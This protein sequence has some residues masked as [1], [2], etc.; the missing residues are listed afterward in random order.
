MPGRRKRAPDREPESA[1]TLSPYHDA[2]AFV[3]VRDADDATPAPTPAPEPVPKVKTTNKQATVP[4]ETFMFVRGAGEGHSDLDFVY[5][6]HV[7]RNAASEAE[8]EA[9]ERLPQL[10]NGAGATFMQRHESVKRKRD[11][12][13]WTDNLPSRRKTLASVAVLAVL[14]FGVAIVSTM[15]GSTPGTGSDVAASWAARAS[16]TDLLRDGVEA[17]GSAC[18]H[19]VDESICATI[20]VEGGY[21]M[22]SSALWVGSS[23]PTSTDVADAVVV[24]HDTPVDTYTTCRP[25]SEAELE[26]LRCF[27]VGATSNAYVAA[28]A[29]LFADEDGDDAWGRGPRVGKTS[30]T[31]AHLQLRCVPDRDRTIPKCRTAFAYSRT[32]STCF[33]DVEYDVDSMPLSDTFGWTSEIG[34]V[35]SSVNLDLVVADDAHVDGSCDLD[36]STSTIGTVRV[37]LDGNKNVKY[38]FDVSDLAYTPH[39]AKIYVGRTELPGGSSSASLRASAFSHAVSTPLGRSDFSGVVDAST[40]LPGDSHY[41]HT[42]IKLKVCQGDEFSLVDTSTAASTSQ[43]WVDSQDG[44]ESSSAGVSGIPRRVY[45]ASSGWRGLR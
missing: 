15:G 32:A 43:A 3:Y 18:V 34:P 11:D 1:T 26:T 45:E 16:C 4:R 36:A 23:V 35:D 14:G 44:G 40:D 28:S 17:V 19:V 7:A 12:A 22:E 38:E 42:I 9:A 37:T 2:A 10:S 27:E 29:R 8:A 41:V 31:Y 20:L 30:F 21:A 24:H 33:G 39:E 5:N 6:T 13:G 25:A